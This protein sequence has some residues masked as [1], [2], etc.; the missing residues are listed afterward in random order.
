MTNHHP[1]HQLQLVTFGLLT[2]LL[3]SSTTVSAAPADGI[4]HLSVDLEVDPDPSQV[5]VTA[6][7]ATVAG[8]PG[9][10][11]ALCLDVRVQPFVQPSVPGAG[12]GV[13]GGPSQCARSTNGDVMEELWL[14]ICSGATL[15]T[16]FLVDY[17]G[18]VEVNV[19]DMLQQV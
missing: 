17:H 2:A 18:C 9:T 4:A 14:D 10:A 6:D 5:L 11:Q 19:G 7:V 1:H 8:I 3:A 15:L 16:D 13:S 12:T